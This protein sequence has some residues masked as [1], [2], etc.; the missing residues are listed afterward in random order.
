MT[1]N[2]QNLEDTL[3]ITTGSEGVTVVGR[4]HCGLVRKNNEDTFGAFSSLGLFAV[5][6]GMGGHAAGEIASDLALRTFFHS[7]FESRMGLGE[8]QAPSLRFQRNALVGAIHRAHHAIREKATKNP[9]LTGMGTTLAAIQVHQDAMILGHVGDSRIYR[10]NPLRG[11][12]QLTRDHSLAN[13]LMQKGE[14]DPDR[15]REIRNVL[16]NAV[17][18][19]SCRP[20]TSVVQRFRGD[21]YLLCSDGLSDLV[22]HQTITRIMNENS[23]SLERAAQEL[24]AAANQAGGHDNIT[25]VLVRDDIGSTQK[26]KV[27]RIP[28]ISG[29]RNLGKERA[30]VG[31]VRAT[32]SSL[33]GRRRQPSPR[34]VAG[35]R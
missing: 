34:R 31:W 25:V 35:T 13:A 12:K 9:Q 15:V 16:V 29:R 30:S 21:V 23:E 27:R 5:C 26:A 4:T 3:P 8:G 18:V 2:A 32:I 1:A 11:L 28:F 33:S 24:V 19:T 10:W 6:D 7:I 17:G 20:E 14:L 22:D